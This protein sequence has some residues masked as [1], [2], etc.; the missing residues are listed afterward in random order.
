[1][2]SAKSMMHSVMLHWINH[3][4]IELIISHVPQWMHLLLLLYLVDHRCNRFCPLEY[5]TPPSQAWRQHV[6]S[7]LNVRWSQYIH[8]WPRIG[9]K[10]WYH[11]WTRSYLIDPS[12]EVFPICH[13]VLIGSRRLWRNYLCCG[14]F[15]MMNFVLTLMR[16]RRLGLQLLWRF[17][18]LKK[19][20]VWN[21]TWL[22]FE[23]DDIEVWGKILKDVRG[24]WKPFSTQNMMINKAGKRPNL[25]YKSNTKVKWNKIMKFHFLYTY[26]KCTSWRSSGRRT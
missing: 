14:W 1:M 10:S 3:V 6:L 2:H 21:S 5:L 13:M 25:K 16:L 8:F 17:V 23:E 24:W 18:V 20:A 7:R 12:I 9:G 4:M 15:Q 11:S 26:L 19:A 22:I